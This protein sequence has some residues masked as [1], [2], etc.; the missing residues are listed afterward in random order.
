MGRRII[1]VCSVGL[2]GIFP[3]FSFFSCEDMALRSLVVAKALGNGDTTPPDDTIP[4]DTN[5]NLSA[6]EISLGTL[7]PGFSIDVTSYS[8]WEQSTVTSITVTPTAE[9]STVGITVNGTAVA[10]GTASG[11]IALAAGPG[12]ITIEVTAED[13]TTTRTYTIAPYRAAALP[14]TSQ[15]TMDVAGDDGELRMGVAWPDP[16]FTVGTGAEFVCITDNLTGLMWDKSGDTVSGSKTW[17]EALS[18]CNGLDLGGH[19]DWRL[20]NRKEL[21]SL[22][23]YEEHDPEEWLNGRVSLACR[24][25]TT[26]LLLLMRRL[27]LSPGQFVCTLATCST[28]IRRITT[29]CWLCGPDRRPFGYSIISGRSHTAI[30]SPLR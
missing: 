23:N 21:R 20:P 26:G 18:D 5:A 22:I 4:P 12:T 10:S 13:G 24:A 9:S 28:K 11:N 30:L 3:V 16:R 29:T 15:T 14:K 8:T 27:L 25:T 17:T 6:L 19:T 1:T 2:C 7:S